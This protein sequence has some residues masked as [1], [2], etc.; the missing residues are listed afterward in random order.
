MRALVIGASGQI[1]GHLRS[2]LLA[3]GDEVVGTYGSVAQPGLRALDL[4]DPDAACALVAEVRPDVVLLPAGWTWVDGNEDDRARSFLLNCEVP[5]RIAEACRDVGA[6]FVT[7]STDY[8]FDGAAGPYAEDDPVHPL[9]VYGEAKL[10][11]E[12]ELQATGAECLVLRTTTV[13]GPETQGKNFVYQL[14]RRLRAGQPFKI[15]SDQV[16]TPSYGPD[17]AAATLGLLERGARGV[18]H[19]AGPDVLDRAAFALV[20]CDVFDLDYDAIEVKTT[21]EL[22]QRAERPLL[23]GLKTDKLR[24]AGLQVRGVREGL[25][26]MHAAIEAGEAVAP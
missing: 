13:Y 19:V 12:R 17:V 15:P 10:Q 3:R 2:Q 4:E 18:W 1:G 26:A 6:V 5:R 22:G 21:A 8:V 25:Q 9:N 7:Y 14:V 16:A 20:A 23:A 11:A 24:A